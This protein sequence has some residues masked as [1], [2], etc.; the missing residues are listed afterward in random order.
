MDFEFED[1]L[2]YE[3][4]VNCHT[5]PLHTTLIANWF[6]CPINGSNLEVKLSI[7]ILENEILEI[8]ST[9]NS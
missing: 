8:G 3:P 2:P 9:N 7:K 4:V 5:S 6:M 1:L